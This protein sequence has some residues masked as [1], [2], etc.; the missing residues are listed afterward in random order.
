MPFREDQAR[1][2]ILPS[3]P[4]ASYFQNRD[5]VWQLAET[6]IWWTQRLSTFICLAKRWMGEKDV[7]KLV[8]WNAAPSCSPH[9]PFPLIHS[10]PAPASCINSQCS[11][12]F[13]SLHCYF[14]R[15]CS[16]K[17]GPRLFSF[18]CQNLL[19]IHHVLNNQKNSQQ[20]CLVSLK[21]LYCICLTFFSGNKDSLLLRQQDN[22]TLYPESVKNHKL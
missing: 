14:M 11:I 2:S 16:T 5:K 3:S 22:L 17:K 4:L 6:G 8:I 20:S 18:H 1:K 12:W 9:H 19:H 21:H 10:F 7:N 13:G 15:F